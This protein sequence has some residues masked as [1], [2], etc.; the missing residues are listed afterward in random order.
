[1]K[2]LLVNPPCR[3][4]TVLPLGLG[5]IASVLRK[6]GH[7]V[8]IMDLN[9][10]N[11]SF[12]ELEKDLG[13][14]DCDVI[15][16]GGLTTTYSFIKEFS[17]LAK[18]VKPKTKVIAGN[19][20]STAHPELLMEN[21]SVD[22]CVIDE[23]EET[24]TELANRLGEFPDIENI[25]GIVFRKGPVL[26]RTPPRN[27][28]KDLDSLPFPAWDLFP[29]ETYITST[30]HREFGKRSINITAVR[31]CPFQCIYCSRPFGP[32][33][34][35]RSPDSVISEI[36]ELKKCYGVEFISFTDDLFTINRKWLKSL[37]D[38]MIREDLGIGWAASARVNLVDRDILGKMKLAGCEIL[39]YGFE[40]GSQKILDNMKKGVKVEQA[41][42]A[43]QMTR[44]AGIAI[45]GSFMIGM[46]G[47]TAET[48][49]ETVDFIKR[50]ELALHR[51]FYTTPYPGTPLYQM[52]KDM[53]KIPED[54]DM[55]V[56]S[57]GEM[58]N[59]LLVNLTDMDDG[60]LK[61]LKGDAEE[62]IKANFSLKTKAEIAAIEAR[63]ISARLKNRIREGGA[64][65]TLKWSFG[66]AKEK[67]K[68]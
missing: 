28:I 60:E 38:A 53:G 48:V 45:E 31:G 41:E 10:E 32:S 2:I 36:R 67:I 12:P 4:P 44:K 22:I 25:K 30:I 5:Y 46:I 58:Y 65:S 68:K 50:T 11:R 9:A 3:V 19:M 1:M 62:A 13:A 29:M 17:A 6:N 21:S 49:K 40:S 56:G 7:T 55:Y 33:V 35:M 57:L 27:R 18:K 37:C 59:T 39:G 23:G 51:F 54:E 14:S 24:M 52:A 63:R 43:I 20:V 61:K 42:R 34:Y 16:I 8:S 64:L 26:V 47:E 15:G 66:K